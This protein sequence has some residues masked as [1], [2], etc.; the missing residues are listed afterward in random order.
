MA[1]AI[2]RTVGFGVG[3]VR[4]SAP[5]TARTS[6]SLRDQELSELHSGFGEGSGLVH[7]E[8]VDAGEYLDGGEFLDEAAPSG[9]PD[10]RCLPKRVRRRRD[11]PR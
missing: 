8:H 3:S 10:P 11:R 5:S 9:E 6:A 7:A 4:T 2:A 1:A